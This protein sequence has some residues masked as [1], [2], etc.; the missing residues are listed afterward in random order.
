MFRTILLYVDGPDG[1]EARIQLAVG[2]A[3]KFDATL[4][5]LTAAQLRLPLELYDAALGTVAIGPDYGELDQTE[6]EAEFAKSQAAFTAATKAAGIESDWRAV[7]AAPSEAIAEIA[8]TADLVILGSGDDSLLGD[9][10]APSAGDVVLRI[11]RPILV[12]PPVF[13][14]TSIETIVVA[15]KNTPEAQR[16]LADAVP[17]M[18]GAA[19]VIVLGIQEGDEVVGSLAY[20]EGFLVRH[21]IAAKIEVRQ[22]GKLAIEDEILECAKRNHAELIVSGAYGHTRL[23]EWVFGGVTRALLTRSPI[24]CLFS[25]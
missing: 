14:Q 15:W 18:K 9:L 8:T 2:L 3:H 13:D 16:A 12:V 22:R 4:I 21:G 5:G 7:F 25:H 10:G 17:F 19:T 6:L 11:G 24:P 1:S 20:A 23:R